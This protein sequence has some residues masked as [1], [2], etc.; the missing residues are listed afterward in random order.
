M[1]SL[2]FYQTTRLPLYLNFGNKM[3]EVRVYIFLE[4]KYFLGSHFCGSLRICTTPVSITI[5]HFVKDKIIVRSSQ[6]NTY[7]WGIYD[8]QTMRSKVDESGKI[9]VGCRAE[10]WGLG[11]TFKILVYN[12]SIYIDKK[13]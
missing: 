10:N 3:F 7:F 6:L 1:A 8:K 4:Y 11:W 13:N 2:G 12:E 9:L 5:V